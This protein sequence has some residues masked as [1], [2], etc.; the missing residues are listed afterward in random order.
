MDNAVEYVSPHVVAPLDGGCVR[1]CSI[2]CVYD[3][4]EERV[5]AAFRSSRLT[6]LPP[7]DNLPRAW[8]V[9]AEPA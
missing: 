5:G 9:L 3:H 6:W 2:V 7:L 8:G 4:V 1:L